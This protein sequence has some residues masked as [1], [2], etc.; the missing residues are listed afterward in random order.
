MSAHYVPLMTPPDSSLEPVFRPRSIAVVG[1]S[2]TPGTVGYEIVDNLLADR[3]TGVVYPVNPSAVAVHSIPA[4]ARL[5]DI[6][7]D[8]DLA[9]IAVPKERAL[10]AA[11][12]C[13]RKGVKA[14]VGG[15]M[16]V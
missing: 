11:E 10:E 14:L 2:R 16:R 9:V 1:A 8:V 15:E 6:P 3:F 5:D 4:Y 7:G 12:A 13:G